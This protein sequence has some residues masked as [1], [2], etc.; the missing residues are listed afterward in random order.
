VVIG[1]DYTG[2]YKFN[3]YAITNTRPLWHEEHGSY[4]ENLKTTK[5]ATNDE[6]TDKRKKNKITNND[7]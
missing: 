4:Y 3:Y 2:S 7:S 5:E 1:T 6:R